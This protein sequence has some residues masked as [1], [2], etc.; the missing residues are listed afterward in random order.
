[1]PTPTT[2]FSPSETCPGGQ[3]AIGALPA[4]LETWRPGGQQTRCDDGVIAPVP[5]GSCGKH[6]SEGLW[7]Q[8]GLLS[9]LAWQEW[10]LQ[11]MCCVPFAE[12]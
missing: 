9:G 5:C 12:G 7:Q 3:Q 1:M 10:F 2:S 11:Q 6:T 4:L 8:N